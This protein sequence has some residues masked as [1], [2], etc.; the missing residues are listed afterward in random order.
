MVRQDSILRAKPAR[1]CSVLNS[2]A[3]KCR[4]E[5]TPVRH[6]RDEQTERRRF[7]GYGS[8]VNVLVIASVIVTAV[9]ST[10]TSASGA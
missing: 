8:G 2:A 10:L 5:G 7:A 4:V 6:L 1:G 3:R 9:A